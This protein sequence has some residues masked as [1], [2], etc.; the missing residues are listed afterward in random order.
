MSM[1][2]A[3]AFRKRIMLVLF[4]D[5][6]AR[7]HDMASAL[8]QAYCQQNNGLAFVVKYHFDLH[9]VM[10]ELVGYTTGTFIPFFGGGG[11]R[12]WRWEG[13]VVTVIF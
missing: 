2:N 1:M 5:P 3:E 9:F 4:V 10:C 8:A 13:V 12:W 7:S 11:G 6:Q